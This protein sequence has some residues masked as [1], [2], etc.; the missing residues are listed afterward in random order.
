MESALRFLLN[1]NQM[2]K[3]A[4]ILAM[5]AF[6]IAP[7]FA[8]TKATENCPK[9]E[10]KECVK[11][12]AKTCKDCKNCSECKDCK[13]C[14]NCTDCKDCNQCKDCK[15]CKNCTDCK[16]CNQCKD[17]KDCKECKGCNKKAAC[18]SAIACKKSKKDCKKACEGEECEKSANCTKKEL[19]Q[20]P[21][22]IKCPK[23]HK[24][25]HRKFNPGRERVSPFEG[26]DLS[27]QQKAELKKIQD[28]RK[29]AVEKNDTNIT[30]SRAQLAKKFDESVKNILTPEQYAQYKA[31]LEKNRP[32]RRQ[33]KI[34][35]AKAPGRCIRT[36]ET[37]KDK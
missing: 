33:I 18:D 10:C 13:D 20:N 34:D 25:G 36:V 23:G 16:D 12:E 5:C 1:L 6:I 17:C 7:T 30:E 28:D 19:R 37:P 21:E 24:E 32:Q 31:N 11:G 14:K 29:A 26:I 22:K 27:E 3:F 15:D 2:K 9:K 4:M 35:E 8:Q